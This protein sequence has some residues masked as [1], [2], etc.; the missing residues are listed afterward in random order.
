MGLYCNPHGQYQSPSETNRFKTTFPAHED[1][2][3]SPFV[4]MVGLICTITYSFFALDSLLILYL[5]LVR[6]KRKYAST[7]RNSIP[8]TDAK[9]L[10]RIQL[11]SRSLVPIS[12]PYSY[13][14]YLTHFGRVTQICVCA[15]QLWKTDDTH[16]RF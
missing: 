13:P 5:T 1:Y 9:M 2:I 16:L 7:V 4:K 15:L 11:D 10:E 6:P 8:F 3:F 14:C 12:F